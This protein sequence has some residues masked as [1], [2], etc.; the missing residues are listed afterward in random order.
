MVCLPIV[1][2]DRE[3]LQVQAREMAGLGP[4]LIEW[5]VDGYGRVTDVQ[6]CC[7]SLSVLQQIIHPIPLIFT[8]RIQAEAGMAE[9]S[10]TARLDLIL[11]AMKTGLVDILDIELCNSRE[12]VDSVTGAAKIF[13]TR[14]ILSCHD[15][16]NTP[17]KDV[18]V[19]KLA[20][21]QERGADIAKLAAMPRG[22]KDVLTLMAATLAARQGL[23]KIPMITVSMGEQG[24]VSRVA[25]GVFGSDITFAMGKDA[26]APGQM[27]IQSLRKAMSA[28]YP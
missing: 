25:G 9:I 12:F 21:A 15:F 23:V 18:I 7:D 5:R 16:E 17:S 6:E 28:L 20:E 2:S 19:G 10:D 1:A 11:R 27:P 26:S 13:D 3:D 22:H 8:C 4:D 14:I 24:A